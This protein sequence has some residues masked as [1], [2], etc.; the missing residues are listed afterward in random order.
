METTSEASP[1][2]NPGRNDGKTTCFMYLVAGLSAIGGLLFGYDTGVVSGAMLLMR[3][4]FHLDNTMQGVVVSVTIITAWLFCLMAG[5]AADKFGRKIVIVIASVVFTAGS[6]VMGLSEHVGLLIAGRIIVGIGIGKSSFILCLLLFLVFQLY[7][8]GY[9]FVY[10]FGGK[11]MSLSVLLG[12][13]DKSRHLYC[14]I[15]WMSSSQVIVNGLVSLINL[16]GK[17]I[18]KNTMV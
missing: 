7:A 8:P 11:H 15:K 5:Q 4:Y 9:H 1:V 14:S 2:L 6:I 17:T 10:L 3:D 13:T 18:E 12:S 16:M